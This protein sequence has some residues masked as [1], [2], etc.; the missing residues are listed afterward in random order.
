MA[1]VVRAN[2]RHHRGDSHETRQEAEA[3]RRPEFTC[4]AVE[5]VVDDGAGASSDPEVLLDQG[6]RRT[7]LAADDPAL[8]L[9]HI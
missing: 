5:D 1:R 6:P 4:G 8:S 3:L 2:G 9:I 7:R